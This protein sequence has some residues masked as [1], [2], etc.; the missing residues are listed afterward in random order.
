MRVIDFHCDTPGALFT[1]RNDPGFCAMAGTESTES[2]EFYLQF[3]A[4]FCPRNSDDESGCKT[5]SEMLDWWQEKAKYT[6]KC[7]KSLKN[8][9]FENKS[10]H[11]LAIEDA[12]ILSG[13]LA[14]V[15]AL[16]SRGVRLMTPLWRGETCMGGA[17]DT[18][19][20]LS[21][22]GA[23]AVE[24]FLSL[25]GLVDVSHASRKAHDEIAALC[26]RYGRA[27]LATHS[28]AFA[29]T[30]H[31]RNL[32]DAQIRG[33]A[34]LGGVIGLNFYPAFLSQSGEADLD[35]LC[36]HLRR[37]LC[38][39]GS[40]SAVLGSDL[41]GVDAL[42][43]G[44]SSAADLPRFAEHMQKRGFTADGID[45]FFFENGRRYLLENLP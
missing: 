26:R 20:G 7:K 3:S 9:L 12:R 30:P 18:D 19:E 40:A 29:L 37:I 24:R 44:I 41:D 8:A 42:P 11:L 39:G 22:F 6:V 21:P 31:P 34:E 1:H 35:D 16:F 25:G 23:A 33:I 17:W 45:A 5:I 15:D 28:D 38:V 27:P 14:R 2:F 43:R 4:F 32:T 10:A 36:A 13:D